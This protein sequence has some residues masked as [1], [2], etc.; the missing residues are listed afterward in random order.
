MSDW[1]KRT[2]RHVARVVIELDSRLAVRSGEKGVFLDA[3]LVTD[4]SGL[5]A[6]P[7][8]SLAGVVRARWEDIYGEDSARPL[9][10]STGK[11]EKDPGLRSRVLFS[12]AHLHDTENRPVDGLRSQDDLL[13]DPVLK[14]AI[15]PSFRDHV[16]LNHRGAADGRGKFDRCSLWA[17][18][19]FSFEIELESEDPEGIEE[20]DRLVGV[21]HD[22]GTLLGG[23]TRSGLG[24]FSVASYTARSFDLT[25]RASLEA[26][27]R[28]GPGVGRAEGLKTREFPKHLE[29]RAPSRLKIELTPEEAW[30]FGDTPNGDGEGPDK[31]ALAEPRVVWPDDHGRVDA[32]RYV[33]PGSAVK[34]AFRHRM[35]FHLRVL[36]EKW[37]DLDANFESPPETA[38]DTDAWAHRDLEELD[39]AMGFVPPRK[40][41]K[42]SAEAVKKAKRGRLLFSD[43]RPFDAPAPSARMHVSLDRFTGAPMDGYL[44]ED[45][46]LA[47]GRIELEVGL[48]LGL[49]GES[50]LDDR[51]SEALARTVRDLCEGRL[52]LGAGSG[53]GYGWFEGRIVEKTGWFEKVLG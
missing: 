1:S 39:A 46:P 40:K 2:H 53:K 33:V 49:D 23:A 32:A 50:P 31:I 26:Y 43:A 52:Q 12:W 44:F 34:G 36:K 25:D 15:T 21:L 51:I 27:G 8:G 14:A 7:A 16:R 20:L 10:G 47:G 22:P 11:G 28:L 29:G 42:T 4:A 30:L 13:E 35:A 18:H 45:E 24:A 41:R 6:I 9:F 17:G 19:R 48:E 38:L 3:A 5:P 37:A